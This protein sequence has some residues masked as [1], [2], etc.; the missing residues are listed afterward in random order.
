MFEFEKNK[1]I[2]VI[3]LILSAVIITLIIL[4]V[5]K[6]EPSCNNASKDTCA[7]VS[8]ADGGPF[9]PVSDAIG[10]FWI[11][12]NNKKYNL[13]Q[14]L[15]KPLLLIDAIMI[16]V[17]YNGLVFIPQSTGSVIYSSSNPTMYNNPTTPVNG[18]LCYDLRYYIF[19]MVNWRTD[20]NTVVVF[21]Q[22]SVLKYAP[23]S[24]DS[25]RVGNIIVIPVGFNDGVNN[26]LLVDKTTGK[27]IK[28]DQSATGT[29]SL[30]DLTTLVIDYIK[31][32]SR[33]TTLAP[34]NYELVMSSFSIVWSIQSALIRSTVS[35]TSTTATPEF[36]FLAITNTGV[37]IVSFV[38]NI[39]A[40][41]LTNS[42]YIKGQNGNLNDIDEILSSYV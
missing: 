15:T 18:I 36:K 42:T 23:I 29:V 28:D 37:S 35:S 12:K 41:A 3:C 1:F 13:G 2:I 5:K 6:P 22:T 8:S 25:P 9:L 40:Y 21:D 34:G 14:G 20:K 32:E 39:N 26:V 27:T 16:V 38:P 30:A 33:S 7:S 4:Y 10:A 31:Q 11:D 24:T 17:P 19:K